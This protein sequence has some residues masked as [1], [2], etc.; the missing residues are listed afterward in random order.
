MYAAGVLSA[1]ILLADEENT[2]PIAVDQ[3]LSL[4]HELATKYVGETPFAVRLRALINED[5]RWSLAL[6]P[7]R[8]TARPEMREVASRVIPTELWWE[9]VGI[10]LRLFPGACPESFCRDF[11]DA[12]SFALDAIFEKPLAELE[13]IQLRTRSLVVTDWDQ[14]NEILE[15]IDAV[16]AKHRDGSTASDAQMTIAL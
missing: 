9:T 7:H 11:G 1:R 16:M 2:L 13:L 15:A 5:P 10:I 8:L 6:G 12:P 14:N 4:A 3:L